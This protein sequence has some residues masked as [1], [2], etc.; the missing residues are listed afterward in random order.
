M[1]NGKAK[2]NSPLETGGNSTSLIGA[3]TTFK[4]DITSNA[5]LR[6][7]GTITGNIYSTA[8]VHYK[9]ATITL[10]VFSTSFNLTRWE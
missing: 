7:D 10:Y 2:S 6:I 8:I 5:D 1:F 9:I 3:G 4:G